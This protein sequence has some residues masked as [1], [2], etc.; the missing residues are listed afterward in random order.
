MMDSQ[1]LMFNIYIYKIHIYIIDCYFLMIHD[2]SLVQNQLN[3]ALN[4]KI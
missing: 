2:I 3:S 1:E 4:D